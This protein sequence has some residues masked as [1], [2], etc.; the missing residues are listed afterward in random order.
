MRL[1]IGEWR[2]PLQ[3]A[4]VS[5][6]L[7]LGGCAAGDESPPSPPPETVESSTV[8]PDFTIVDSMFSQMMIPHHKQALE[9][10][11]LV[12][13]RT[14][15]PEVLALAAAIEAAQAPE[16]EQMTAWLVGWGLP[17]EIDMELHREHVGMEGMLTEEQLAALAAASGPEFDRLW[18]E[19]MI[20][21][22]EGAVVMAETVV[23]AGAHPPTVALAVE[24]IEA[25]ETEIELMQAL[26]DG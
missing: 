7:L 20:A 1:M 12:P 4:A 23:A 17:T 14:D 9:M 11:A 24:I 10:S 18:L 25:Q 8:T 21:H 2:I 26:L 15:N 5:V 19:G 16:I 3:G 6:V 13:E 22:H